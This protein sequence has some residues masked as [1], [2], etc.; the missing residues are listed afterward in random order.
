[1]IL[2][3]ILAS[4]IFPVSAGKQNNSNLVSNVQTLSRALTLLFFSGC[5]LLALTGNWLFPFVYGSSFSSMYV[6]FLFLIP[7]ILSLNVLTLLNA[8][9]AGKNQIRINIY[10][11]LFS[12]CIII[13]GDFL[14]IPRFGIR[15]AAI[16]SSIGYLCNTIFALYY[17]YKHYPHPV[18]D[19]FM[20]R[21]ADISQL[22][23]LIMRT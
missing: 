4:A 12:L 23:A 10:G 19:F 17:F 5:V 1:M 16:V 11:A 14:L 21:R 2:P 18:K 8:Y 13:A 15:A 3:A 6:V 22:T 7:G 9:F 20:V